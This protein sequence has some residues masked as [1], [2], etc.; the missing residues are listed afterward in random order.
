MAKLKMLVAALA[1]LGLILPLGAQATETCDCAGIVIEIPVYDMDILPGTWN[2]LSEMTAEKEFLLE[3]TSGSLYRVEA[4]TV[5]P[6]MAAA[7]PVDVTADYAGSFGIPADAVRGYAFRIDLNEEACWEDGVAITADDWVFTIERYSEIEKCYVNLAV[8]TEPT[9]SQTVTSLEEAGFATVA[10]AR[11]AGF[12]DFYLDISRFWGLEGGWKALTDR[13][14]FRDYAIPSGL[15]EYYVSAAYLY[16]QYLEEGRGYDR[17]QPEM[18]GLAAENTREETPGYLKT[19]DRQLTL[20]L[21]QPT[22]S[23]ALAAQLE[24]LRPMRSDIWG[25]EYATSVQDY[26][27]CGPYRVETVE[28]GLITLAGNENWYGPQDPKRPA[29]IRCKPMA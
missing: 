2:P 10:Q 22:T 15:D 11:E 3:M 18:I 20:I 13:S 29:L 5:T 25:P 16:E 8:G 6:A 7:L 14:R 17:W 21:N 9:D 12:A 1:L 19:G 26:S 4:G 24:D 28:P 23:A 27:A